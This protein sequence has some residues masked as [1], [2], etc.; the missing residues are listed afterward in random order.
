MLRNMTLAQVADVVNGELLQPEFA[1]VLIS[2]V[3]TD[4]RSLIDGALYIPLSGDNFNGHH[5]I[6][7]AENEGA[8]AALTSEDVA[9]SLPLI[10]VDNTLLALGR[11]AGW[12]R[13]QFSGLVIAVTGSAGKTSVKQLTAS[14][15][16]QTFNT[17]M[18]QGNLN[19]HIGAPLTLLALKPEHEAAMIELGASGLGEIAYTAQFVKPLVGIITNAVPAHIEGFGSLQ[20]I[21][22]T[23]G[24]L[25]DFIQPNGTAVLNA[26]DANLAQWQQRAAHL[27]QLAFG[28]SELADV[29]ATNIRCSLE[30][31]EFD[32]LCDGQTVAIKLPL[33]GEHNVRNALAVI[34]ATHAAGLSW[35]HIVKGLQASVTVKGRLQ[36][37]RG[38]AGQLI[39]N[40]AYNANPT[41]FKAAIDVLK[42]TENSWVVMGDMG[43]LGS[44]EIAAHTDVGTYAKTSGI[45]HFVAT[46]PLSRN[47]ATAFGESAHWF[48][49]KPALIRFLQQHTQ[50]QDVLL[51]K[52][53]RYTGMDQVV[54][55]LQNG[56]EEI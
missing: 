56:N 27:Q 37:C 36:P 6:A 8:I 53:S 31:S 47:A 34:A 23:K 42:G 28:F 25:L 35:D 45:E 14:I 52:G 49:D 20:G 13:D 39:L 18:T 17:W 4:T 38:A 22:E 2:S 48:E 3:S 54:A 19:N 12:Q 10:R 46:G 40:D 29:R 30:G 9:T 50:K 1:D 15:L 33:L 32:V 24:E 11:I 7:Q 55:A 51:I 43:E 5:F 26:D 41:A 44:D 21:V 16:T